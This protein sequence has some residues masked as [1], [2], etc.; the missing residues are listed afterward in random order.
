MRKVLC[1]L[2][3]VAMI[4]LLQFAPQIA[5]GQTIPVVGTDGALE[6]ATW[7]IEWFG[8]TSNG[9][10]NDAGK[11]D[12]KGALQGLHEMFERLHGGH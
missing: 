12:P 1:R 4:H 11:Q 10:G 2:I 5:W 7:N 3:V 6:V 8:S 9:P